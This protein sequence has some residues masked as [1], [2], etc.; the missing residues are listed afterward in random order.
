[1]LKSRCVKELFVRRELLPGTAGPDLNLL[2]GDVAWEERRLLYGSLKSHLSTS[3]TFGR[4]RHIPFR[5]HPTDRPGKLRSWG[6]N[7]SI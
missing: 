4:N 6:I 5:S 7:M 1:M 3:D 2:H